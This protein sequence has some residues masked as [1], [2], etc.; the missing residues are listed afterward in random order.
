M[1]SFSKLKENIDTLRQK[2]RDAVS[3]FKSTPNPSVDREKPKEREHNA[4]VGAREKLA[5]RLK[6]K[7]KAMQRQAMVNQ[8]RSEVQ[9]DS[10]ADK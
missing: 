6:A 10:K 4:D 5:A 8:V 9:Q 7:R 2:Q 3:K 1:K